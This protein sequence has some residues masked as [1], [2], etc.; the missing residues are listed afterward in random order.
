MRTKHFALVFSTLLCLSL[1][2]EECERECICEPEWPLPPCNPCEPPLFV[3]NCMTWVNTEFLFW[4]ADVG[5][6]DYAV[7]MNQSTTAP[8][9]FAIGHYQEAKY[10]W[11]P[12]FR[13]AIGYYN[14]PRFWEVAAQYTWFYDKGHHH[15]QA[16]DVAGEFL[17]PTWN[18]VTA[19]PFQRA[20]SLIDL[21][22][23][24]GDLIVAR[25]FDT[26]PHMRLKL[27]GAITSGYISQSWKMR[28]SDFNGSFDRI[29]SRWHYIATGLRMG[30]SIDWFWG[31]QFY[32]TGKATI[33]TLVGSYKNKTID[34]LQSG[35]IVG[36]ATYKDTRVAF[37]SQILL[38]PSWQRP[39]EC[40][41][42]EFFAGYELNSWLNLH[43]TFR[44]Q[45]SAQNA[46]KETRHA[47]GFLGM[48][49]LTARLTIGF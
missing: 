8:A 19:P 41:T 16:P 7:K 26:N 34:R 29:K 44:S 5:S 46:Q 9:T 4:S 12:G 32:F 27:L 2:A 23:H 14:Y 38:G 33:A 43:E 49:G 17:N 30:V 6:V 20:S 10:K 15:V 1:I 31:Y 47:S 39:C 37:H 13:V 18:T 11:E 35:V 24:L 36:D 21:H 48:Q 28:F 25:I 40:W 22:Y 45:L 3:Y 42:M